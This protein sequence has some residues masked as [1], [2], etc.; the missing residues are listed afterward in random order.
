M[1]RGRGRTITLLYTHQ[2][3]S[4]IMDTL[5]RI[6]YRAALAITATWK[7]TN[8]NKLYDGLVGNPFS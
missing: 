3:L 5:E 6:Q 8:L 7:G 4:I 1:R 2:Q